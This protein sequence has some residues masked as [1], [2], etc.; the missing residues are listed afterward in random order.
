MQLAAHQ[1]NE[2]FENTPLLLRDIEETRFHDQFRL[3]EGAKH[4][5]L[6]MQSQLRSLYNR[7]TKSLPHQPQSFR[8]IVLLG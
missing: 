1:G 3:S 2:L 8:P 5:S 6:G 4:D 7:H